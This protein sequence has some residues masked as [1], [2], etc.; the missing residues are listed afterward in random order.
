M[1]QLCRLNSISNHWWKEQL[2]T[3]S[4]F[5]RL[6][7]FKKH[8]LLLTGMAIAE[9][10][11]QTALELPDKVAIEFEDQRLTFKELDL[12]ANKAANAYHSIGIRK[13]DRIAH[14]LPNCIELINSL[15]G[16]FKH[17]FVIVPM[18]IN[19]KE[20]EIQHILHDSGAKAIITDI[21]HLPTVRNVLST[22]PNLRHIILINGAEANTNSFHDLLKKSSDKKPNIQRIFW[23]H[24]RAGG[25]P[26]ETDST[27]KFNF[28]QLAWIPGSDRCLPEDD[29]KC[30]IPIILDQLSA[31]KFYF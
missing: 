21:E 15:M 20:Q 14:Y 22:L 2:K 5:L 1:G 11:S 16:C 25:N 7:K 9:L 23:C 6:I 30:V 31:Q 24:S 3:K 8:S 29:N 13:G 27:F 4:E 28:A 10:F 12:L 18:N 26:G 19:F 17:G